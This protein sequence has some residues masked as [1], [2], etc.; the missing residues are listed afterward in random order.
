VPSLLLCGTENVIALREYSALQTEYVLDEFG[1]RWKGAARGDGVDDALPSSREETL[2]ST[3]SSA[4][5]A[6][7]T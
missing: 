6:V 1:R 2:V 7:G 4:P 3:S 5:A